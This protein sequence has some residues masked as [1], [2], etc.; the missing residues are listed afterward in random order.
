MSIARSAVCL[1]G[2]NG[3]LRVPGDKSI[4]HRALIFG[5]LAE[6]TTVIEGISDGVDVQSTANCLKGLGVEITT[7]G[8]QTV[9]KGRGLRGLKAPNDDLN[10]GNSGTTMRLLMGVLA[11]QPFTARLIGDASLCRRPMERVAEP[12]RRMGAAF[13]LSPGGRAPLLVHGG[14]LRGIRFE[15]Q[16]AS[17]QVKSAVLLAGLAA[18]GETT[19]VESILSRDHTERMLVHFGV[20]PKRCA[21]EVTISGGATLRAAHVDVPGDPS[22][23][24]FWIVAAT[25]V[26]GSK[27]QICGVSANS[28]RTQFLNVLERMGAHIQCA[29][30]SDVT[31]LREPMC[32][33]VVSSAP[34]KAVEVTAAEIPGLIDEVPILAL[35]A[36]QA[37]GVSRFRNLAELRHKE[38]DRLESIVKLLNAL[39]GHAEIDGDDLI[40]KGPSTLQA[41]TLSGG[42]D[43]RIAMTALVAGL[44]ADGETVVTDAECINIS[45]PTFY[46]QLE[47]LLM[48]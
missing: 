3:T 42:G 46:P 16:V 15:S 12:L 43:H 7:H 29:Y 41:T 9:V 32:D 6:G 11:S 2:L 45:Y 27:L 23:A 33:I 37:R 28:T 38:S 47:A 4:S 34:L 5:A 24:A 10:A 14:V 1:R 39:G 48:E 36:S 30:Q 18:H 19:V 35:A 26:A 44:I 21:T 40:V 25:I 20:P 13:D 22:S 31:D 8:V 17:A